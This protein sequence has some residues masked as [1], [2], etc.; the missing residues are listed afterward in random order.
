MDT[1][2]ETLIFKRLREHLRVTKVVCTRSV[3]GRGGDTYVGFSA[4]WDSIQD[5]AGGAAD[6]MSP[7]GD[8]DTRIA[9]AQ[10]GMTLREAK[11]AALVLGLQADVAAHDH[12][13]ASGNISPEQRDSAVQAIKANYSHLIAD[14]LG[15]TGG[16][17]DD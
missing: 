2:K 10:I 14:L 3:K 12:S 4:A 11:L 17:K 1:K 5:D 16:G 13:A 7:Q 9:Q 6:L 8:G 15:E